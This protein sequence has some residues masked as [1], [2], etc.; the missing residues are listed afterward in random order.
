LEGIIHPSKFYG[1]K[2]AGVFSGLGLHNPNLIAAFPRDAVG[3]ADGEALV[4]GPD[5]KGGA[6]LVARIKI[7]DWPRLHQ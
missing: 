6:T 3:V 1:K 7:E 2:I 4:F 5:G